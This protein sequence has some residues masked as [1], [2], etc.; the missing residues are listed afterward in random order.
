MCIVF[1][2]LNECPEFPLILLTNRDEFF[3]RP[4][5]PMHFWQDEG[6]RQRVLAGKDLKAGGTW[7]ALGDDRRGE[8]RALRFA[9]VTNVREAQTDFPLS[10][11]D[12]P[13]HYAHPSSPACTTSGMLEVEGKEYGE[14]LIRE[15]EGYGGFNLIFGGLLFGSQ[16]SAEVKDAANADEGVEETPASLPFL[17]HA[18]NRHESAASKVENGVHCVSNHTIDTPWKKAELGK[19]LLRQEVAAL[20]EVCKGRRAEGGVEFSETELGDLA[21]SMKESILRNAEKPKMEDM[22]PTETEAYER[23]MSHQLSSIYVEIEK[24]DKLVYGTR[25]ST[26]ILV[27]SDG[28]VF[29]REYSRGDDGKWTHETFLL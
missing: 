8:K 3:A 24:G 23:N 21:E 15:G 2:A 9:V 6:D 19:K 10:R 16:P 12:L 11:G 7:L 25:A 28:R 22:H 18:T 27:G 4:T 13:T 1:F 5:Q 29:V 20:N 14:R 17:Y 26:V